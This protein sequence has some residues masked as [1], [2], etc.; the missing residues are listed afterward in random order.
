[1]NANGLGGLDLTS[2]GA[3]TGIELNT[4][5]D[6]SGGSLV[7]KV[8]T[9]AK[10]WSSATIP[11]PNTGDGSLNSND[12]QFIAFSSFQVGAGT[13]AN[14]TQ[15]GAVQLSIKGVNA[16]DGQVGPIVGRRTAGLPR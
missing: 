9:D 14:F 6:H 13:G 5:A 2:Q 3:S 11:I 12:S 16:I 15:V 10:D 8:Y 7:L 4:A 1:M